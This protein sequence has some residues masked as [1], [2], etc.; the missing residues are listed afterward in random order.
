M[1]IFSFVEKVG[2]GVVEVFC[3]VG[4]SRMEPFGCIFNQSI[5]ESSP[6]SNVKHSM[7]KYHQPI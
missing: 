4:I 5:S 3:C 6:S 1:R 7:F 2:A